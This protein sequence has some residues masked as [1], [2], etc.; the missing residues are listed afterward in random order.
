MKFVSHGHEFVD[1][2]MELQITYWC[3]VLSSNR[4]ILNFKRDDLEILL[5]YL[6][7]MTGKIKKSDKRVQKLINDGSIY[8]NV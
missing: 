7:V 6:N 5:C 4:L 1:I 8:G 3:S 2:C